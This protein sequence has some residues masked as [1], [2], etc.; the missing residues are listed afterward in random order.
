M[1]P[2]RDAAVDIVPD[3]GRFRKH[4]ADKMRHRRGGLS[5]RD[6]AKKTGLSKTSLQRIENEEQNVTIDTLEHLCKKFKCEPGDL[7]GT[8]KL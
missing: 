3:M 1:S 7:L 4:L 2:M 8:T 5:I 6:F